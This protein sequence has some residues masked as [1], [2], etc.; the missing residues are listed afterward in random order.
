[1]NAIKSLLL[2]SLV[3]AGTLGAP[4]AFATQWSVGGST[5]GTS[6]IGPGPTSVSFLGIAYPCTSTFTVESV[7]GVA[8]VTAASFTGSSVCNAIHANN[9][10][11]A[12]SAP[13]AVSG[14]TPTW[15]ATVSGV[16]VV[17]AGIFT[18]SGTA[19][20]KVVGDDSVPTSTHV[21]LSGSLG[22]CTV[23]SGDLTTSPIVKGI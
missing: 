8:K 16:S 14:S 5:T 9:L 17:A 7:S 19:T 1:M 11:W 3:M 22:V 18:C 15:T 6:I 10:P 13:T 4:A 21:N 2:G 20:I 12:I 23:N